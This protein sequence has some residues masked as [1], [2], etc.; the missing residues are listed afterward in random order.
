MEAAAGRA[1]VPE[2][3]YKQCEEVLADFPDM[4]KIQTAKEYLELLAQHDGK[5]MALNAAQRGVQACGGELVADA[6]A[7]SLRELF[8]KVKETVHKYTVDGVKFISLM[9]P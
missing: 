7:V 2:T 1:I 3:L 6:R 8:Q 9:R 4:A 5:F